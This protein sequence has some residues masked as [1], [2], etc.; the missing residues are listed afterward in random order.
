MS[1]VV[2]VNASPL[3]FLGNAGHLEL[4][5]LLGA[6]RVVVPQPV[7]DEVISGGHADKAARAPIASPVSDGWRGRC[8]EAT[9]S[10]SRRS[11]V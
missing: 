6:S 4:L 7:F 1:D 9:T 2:V 11:S 10:T 5:R 3:I 8:R